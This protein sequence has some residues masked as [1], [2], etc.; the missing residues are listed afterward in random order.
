MD[1]H[2][3]LFKGKWIIWNGFIIQPGEIKKYVTQGQ[4][5]GVPNALF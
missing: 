1:A 4:N 3:D 5:K 2:K